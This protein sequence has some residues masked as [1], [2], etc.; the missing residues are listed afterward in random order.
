[1]VM[2]NEF[3]AVTSG[4]K[5]KKS[6]FSPVSN[7]AITASMSGFAGVRNRFS[8]LQHAGEQI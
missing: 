1:M 5:Q 3:K 6:V 4:A 8:I 7:Q 2:I